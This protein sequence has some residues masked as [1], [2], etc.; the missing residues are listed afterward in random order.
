[1]WSTILEP[2]CIAFQGYVKGEHAPGMVGET[3]KAFNVVHNLNLAHGL[4]VKKISRTKV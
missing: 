2:W 3:Q 4:A 1:M